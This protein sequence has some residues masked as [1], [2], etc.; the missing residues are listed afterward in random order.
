MPMLNPQLFMKIVSR[1]KRYML[2]LAISVLSVLLVGGVSFALVVLPNVSKQSIA[3]EDTSSNIIAQTKSV[4]NDPVAKN[5]TSS[6]LEEK[7]TNQTKTDKKKENATSVKNTGPSSSGSTNPTTNNTNAPP[8]AICGAPDFSLEVTR[9]EGSNDLHLTVVPDPD[10]PSNTSAC[11]EVSY[12]TP[13]ITYPSSGPFCDGSTYSMSDISW[14]V[15]CNIYSE[16]SSGAY[17]LSFT[18]K[19]A[20]GLSST[21]RSTTYIFDYQQQ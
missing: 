3:D 16:T 20:N 21:T 10:D 19:G 17:P 12:S 14:G 18:V 6:S 2:A 9:A 15:A 5:E 7:S 11:S 1:S 4:Q 13:T 8:A